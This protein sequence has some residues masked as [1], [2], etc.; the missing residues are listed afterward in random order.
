MHPGAPHPGAECDCSG[1]VAWILGLSRQTDHPL[2]RRVNGGWINTDAMSADILDTAGLLRA[3]EPQPGAVVVYP[4]PPRRSVGH[5]GVVVEAVDGQPTRVIHCSSGNYRRYQDAIQVT[6][7]EVFQTQ[8]DTV[9]GWYVGVDRPEGEP[10]PITD[11]EMILDVPVTAAAPPPEPVP[12]AEG[13][14][15]TGWPLRVLRAILGFLGR[16]A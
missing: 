7:P 6:G 5:C 9:Y 1:F 15:A 3:C 4:G 12:T 10:E 14:Q 13:S 16:R 8:P 2:Y 11:C